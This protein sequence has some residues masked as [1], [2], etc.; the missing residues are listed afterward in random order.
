VDTNEIVSMSLDLIE[1]KELPADSS[2]YVPGKNIKKVLYGI[3]IGVAELAYAKE[4]NFDCV[5]AHHPVGVVNY[6]KVFWKHLDQLKSK[7]VPEEEAREIIEK[8]VMAL[9]YGAHSRNYDAI[10]SFARLIDIP[11]LNIHCPSD[12]LGRR[13]ISNAIQDLGEE[14]NEPNLKKV[15]DYLESSFKEFQMAKTKI[16]IAK[17]GEETPLGNWIFSHGALTNGGYAI[18][19]CYY[20]YGVDTVIYIHIAPAELSQILK[21]KTGQMMITGHLSSDSIGIN[22]FLDKLEEKGV[23]VTAIGGL[24]R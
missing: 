10:P 3:D 8:K 21:L 1:M 19:D 17:G 9:K 24:I 12:E 4:E 15:V 7:G 2:I 14:R 23:E 20:R 16:E 18:A 11:F 5:I 6:W 13:L 22:P